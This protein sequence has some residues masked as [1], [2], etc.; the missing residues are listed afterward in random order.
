MGTIGNTYDQKSVNYGHA[1]KVWREI[2][3]RYPAGG[4]ISNVA[5]F[6]D[7]GKIPAGTPVT[8]DAAEKTITA[9]TDAQITG[10]DDVA[11][12]GINGYLQEDAPITDANTVATGTVVYAGEIYEYMFDEAV[13]TALKT[14]TTVPQ[15]VWVQ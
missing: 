3:H 9:Y 13:V 7:A 2:R 11:A 1:R 6:V 4:T 15:I 12:L 10:A 8:F 5:D 14:L